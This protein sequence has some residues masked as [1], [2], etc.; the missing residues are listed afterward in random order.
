MQH[1]LRELRIKLRPYPLDQFLAHLLLR[2]R[3]PVA[4]LRGHGVI[5]I[6]HCNDPSDFR[7]I[8]SHEA[9]RIS[10]AV[11]PLMMVMSRNAQ[12]RRLPDI[13]QDL[14]SIFRMMLDLCEL[15]VRQFSILVD[16]MIRNTDLTH[17]MQQSCEIH[18]FAFLLRLARVSCDL[19]GI[20]GYTGRMTV[21]IF[22]LGVNG[23]RQRLRGLFEQCMLILLLFFIVFDLSD[24]GFLH[25]L[26]QIPYG[27]YEQHRGHANDHHVVQ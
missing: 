10:P 17:V 27:E 20:H 14:I 13:A 18:F 9:S 19:G 24:P 2:D 25:L 8:L 1:D 6:R 21:S 11:K 7:Y 12:I 3:I 22:I 5:R 26:L 23:C 16:D 4:P 15:L